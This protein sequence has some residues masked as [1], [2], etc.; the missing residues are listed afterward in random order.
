MDECFVGLDSVG[1]GLGV[2]SVH[3]HQPEMTLVREDEETIVVDVGGSY[4]VQISR[5]ELHTMHSELIDERPEESI[6]LI[7][8]GRD[9][10]AWLAAIESRKPLHGAVALRRLADPR[11]GPLRYAAQQRA[12]KSGCAEEKAV[13]KQRV[14]MTVGP[15]LL[16]YRYSGRGETGEPG[17]SESEDE[18]SSLADEETPR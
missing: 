3:W 16:L 2:W 6:G 7:E 13:G 14:A 8:P 18:D 5:V 10:G 4:R 15:Q 17:E 9:V 12:E 11:R 1:S